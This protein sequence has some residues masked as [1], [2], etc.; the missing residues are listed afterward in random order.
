MGKLFAER[1]ENLAFVMR[2]SSSESAQ[3]SHSFR[4][5]PRRSEGP[6]RILTKFAVPTAPGSSIHLEETWLSRR[7]EIFRHWC[8]PSVMAQT[9]QNFEWILGLDER[10]PSFVRTG[11]AQATN[12][13]AKI[14]EVSP[15]EIFT[16]G[17]RRIDLPKGQLVISTRLDSDDILHPRFLEL[18]RNELHREA[19][20]NVGHGARLDLRTGQVGRIMDASGPFQA[21]ASMD[22]HHIFLRGNHKERLRDEVFANVVTRTPMWCQLVSGTNIA[23]IVRPFHSSVS[24]RELGS[25]DPRLVRARRNLN[26]PG[27]GASLLAGTAFMVGLV[28]QFARALR[29][30]RIFFAGSFH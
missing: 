9:D 22:G 15:Y 26:K 8:A 6:I 28:S 3:S 14:H 2:D 29:L 12:D 1:L 19:V 30:G 24:S 23:N 5:T 16:R 20:V 18:I 4:D 11:I 13:R 25:I 21:M 10:V 27:L 17:F 7:L